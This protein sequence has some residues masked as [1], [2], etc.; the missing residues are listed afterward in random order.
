[1]NNLFC[2]YSHTRLNIRGTHYMSSAASQVSSHSCDLDM[3]ADVFG[4]P[5]SIF[6]SLRAIMDSPH[7]VSG[8]RDADEVCPGA[9]KPG[10]LSRGQSAV[11]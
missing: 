4:L 10:P 8:N 1:M 9:Q 7:E 2:E 5:P 11:S 3:V 6:V